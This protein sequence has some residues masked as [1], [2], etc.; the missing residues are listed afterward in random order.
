MAYESSSTVSPFLFPDHKSSSERNQNPDDLILDTPVSSKPPPFPTL[1]EPRKCPSPLNL[2]ASS[3]LTSSPPPSHEEEFP[4]VSIKLNEIPSSTGQDSDGGVRFGN[5]EEVEIGAATA[6][7][8]RVWEAAGPHAKEGSDLSRE[9]L[10]D[11]NLS[12]LKEGTSNIL[13]HEE[14][15]IEGFIT[16][17]AT[18]TGGFGEQTPAIDHEESDT[19]GV[20]EPSTH[21]S[22]ENPSQEESL[23]SNPPKWDGT[24][25]PSEPMVDVSPSLFVPI[26]VSSSSSADDDISLHMWRRLTRSMVLED[27]APSSPIVVLDIENYLALVKESS[28]VERESRQSCKARTKGKHPT[29]IPEELGV[30]VSQPLQKAI[31]AVPSKSKRIARKETDAHLTERTK[32]I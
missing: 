8:T 25:T 31:A 3:E 11:G 18:Q 29:K 14:A 19:I 2:G 4:D 6:F 27:D 1:Y 30:T 9:A 12:E 22:E 10:F 7:S 32:N 21:E 28:E 20:L 16:A 13:P 26:V 15:I 17:L 24:P 5:S 23:A